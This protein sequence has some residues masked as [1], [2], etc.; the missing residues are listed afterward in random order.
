MPMTLP[1]LAVVLVAVAVGSALQRISGM[2]VGLVVAPTLSLLLGP[3]VGVSLT[4]AT[5]VV[6][7]TVIGA[8]LWRSV[9]WRR[10]RLLALVAVVG[11]L[12]GALLVRELP[13]DWLNVVVGAVVLS[14]LLTSVVLGRAGRLPERQGR[15]PGLS[16]G[17]LGGFLNTVAGVAGPAMVVYAEVTRWEQRSFAA[18]MQAVF[19]TLGLLS[20]LTKV[21]VGATPLAALPPPWVLIAVAATV[22]LTVAL[23]GSVADRV[24]VALAR[25]IAVLVAG[26]GAAVTLLRG[27]IGLLG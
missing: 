13:G 18:T 20:V 14:G 9:D 27:A 15:L 26:T 8:A 2:G 16:A 24:D 10:Y 22:L 1:T 4:N 23:V 11:S 19:A 5:T 25:R 21:G 17:A 7:A 3:A 6:S 12:P